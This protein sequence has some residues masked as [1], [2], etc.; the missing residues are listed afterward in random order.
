MWPFVLRNMICF[1]LG[2]FLLSLIEF[3]CEV[4]NL[5]KNVKSLH[6][7][8]QTDAGWKVIRIFYSNF[9]LRWAK[10]KKAPQAVILCVTLT[11]FTSDI[12]TCTITITA[13]KQPTDIIIVCIQVTGFSCGCLDVVLSIC[14][15]FKENVNDNCMLNLM[16]P[17]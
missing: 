8:E 3:G 7:D 10:K 16:S 13:N 17:S 2:S 15:F 9:Q 12:T 6:T 1:T 5:V 11:Q 14:Y 4:L